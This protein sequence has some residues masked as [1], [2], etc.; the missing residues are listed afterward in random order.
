MTADQTTDELQQALSANNE[1]LP[2]LYI[3]RKWNQ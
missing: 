2:I 1:Y 3:I